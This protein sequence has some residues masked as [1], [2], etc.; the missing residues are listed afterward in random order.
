[1]IAKAISAKRAN[2]MFQ[3]LAEAVSLSIVGGLLEIGLAAIV[4]LV[5]SNM[6]I[7][8]IVMSLTGSLIGFCFSVFVGIFFGIYPAWKAIRLGPVNAL[9][10]EQPIIIKNCL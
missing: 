8:T 2:I 7:L 1:M 4:V 3:F 9:R 10:S 5:I 6:K